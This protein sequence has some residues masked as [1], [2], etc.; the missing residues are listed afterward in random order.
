MLQRKVN[1]VKAVSGVSLHVDAGETLGLVG[2]SGC[3]KT[4]LGK[5]IVGIE[6]P[7]AG[8]IRSTARD[9]P[10]AGQGTAPGTAGPPDDVPGPLR[11]ARP[12]DAGAGDPREPLVIQG[13]GIPQSRTSGSGSCSMRSG[14]RRTRSSAIR[15]SSPVASASGSRWRGC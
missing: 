7:D 3:G 13:M 11:L 8:R 10:P 6:K 2:E 1:S 4:T 14:C 9:L 5:L 15:M 12:A